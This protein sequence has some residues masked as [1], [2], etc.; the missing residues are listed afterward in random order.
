MEV[1]PVVRNIVR[2]CS[3]GFRSYFLSKP[4]NT[5]GSCLF[6]GLI[7]CLKWLLEMLLTCIKSVKNVYKFTLLPLKQWNQGHTCSLVPFV[8]MYN[9]TIRLF[10]TFIL[11]KCSDVFCKDKLLIN[12]IRVWGHWMA[13]DLSFLYQFSFTAIKNKHSFL[14]TKKYF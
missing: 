1:V 4:T 2:T 5:S 12:S 10:S 8:K 6:L 9:Y 14:N 13:S 3:Y 7:Y 11:L